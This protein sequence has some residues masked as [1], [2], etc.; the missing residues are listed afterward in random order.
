MQYQEFTLD[1]LT[2]DGARI[3]T[4]DGFSHLIIDRK[5]IQVSFGG[6]PIYG[7]SQVVKYRYF[8]KFRICYGE[9]VVT[10]KYDLPFILTEISI[11][12]FSKIKQIVAEVRSW[13][14][15]KPTKTTKVTFK[16]T[17]KD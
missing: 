12:T 6:A 11:K 2:E 5:L 14:K 7:E 13:F 9:E 10:K 3:F 17:R 16:I 8:I 4:E 15:K 1:I